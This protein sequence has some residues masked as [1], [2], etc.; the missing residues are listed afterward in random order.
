MFGVAFFAGIFQ[1]AHCDI[2]TPHS[3]S[4]LVL[5]T[6]RGG[7]LILDTCTYLCDLVALFFSSIIIHALD[8]TDS[9]GEDWVLAW[10]SGS[11]KSFRLKSSYGDGRKED[12]GC[13]LLSTKYI[14]T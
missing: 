9:G 2:V 12:V 10:W 13:S 6:Q 5:A 4:V 7:Y 8:L 14:G 11:L 1:L 3:V